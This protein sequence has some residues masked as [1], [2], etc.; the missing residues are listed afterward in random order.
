MITLRSPLLRGLTTLLSFEYRTP[1]KVAT[2][3]QRIKSYNNRL[4]KFE[5]QFHMRPPNLASKTSITF[6]IT[7]P[8]LIR[9][10]YIPKKLRERNTI[11]DDSSRIHWNRLTPN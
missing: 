2:V 5:R 10:R 1:R 9:H 7:V 6:P 11:V 3:K 8:F 4:D